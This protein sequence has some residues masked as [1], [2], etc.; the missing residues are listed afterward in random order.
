MYALHLFNLNNISDKY[1]MLENNRFI[2]N[3]LSDLDIESIFSL[4]SD[5]LN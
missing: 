3:V 4:N 5:L 1:I 2:D